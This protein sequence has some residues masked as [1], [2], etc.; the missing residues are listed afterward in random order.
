MT[1]RVPPLTV[2]EPARVLPPGDTAGD[3]PGRRRGRPVAV[4]ALDRTLTRGDTL[5]PFL[6]R[7][8]GTPAV[9]RALAVA[10]SRDLPRRSRRDAAEALVLQRILGGRPLAEVDRVARG[11]A[12]RLADTR[13]RPDSLARWT[14]HRREGHRLVIASA[15][16]GLYVHHLGRLL[17]A[18][19]VICTEMTVVNGRLTG[20]LRSGNCRG[21]EKRRRVLAHLAEHPATQVWA[22]AEGDSDRPL[23][24]SA[25][26]AIRVTPHRRLPRWADR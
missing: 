11:Y 10:A 3:G 26:V 5:L 19:A 8:A 23:L 6:R 24:A 13:L 15:S 16:P 17:G 20:A 4:W 25:D 2:T 21:A 9:V 1:G 14:W 22:Y 18:D 7:I 12:A